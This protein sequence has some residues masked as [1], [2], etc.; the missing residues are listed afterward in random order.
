[1][2]AMFDHL[3]HIRGCTTYAVK[4]GRQITRESTNLMKT[5][6]SEFYFFVTG[7]TPL[8]EFRLT[9]KVNDQQ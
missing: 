1:M 3:P 6:E 2:P 9:R 7:S 4:K 8:H 5:K